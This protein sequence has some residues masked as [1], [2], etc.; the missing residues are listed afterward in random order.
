[1]T[2]CTIILVFFISIISHYIFTERFKEKKEE[3]KKQLH[4]KVYNNKMYMYP[5]NK[6]CNGIGF[7][8]MAHIITTVF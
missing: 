3:S 5:A 8:C 6:A 7:D 1:M 4:G 2:H